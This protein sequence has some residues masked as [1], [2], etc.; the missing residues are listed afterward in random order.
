M[1]GGGP[2]P[3]AGRPKGSRNKATI[4]RELVAAAALER[5]IETQVISPKQ[6][7]ASLEYLLTLALE[8]LD[9]AIADGP[10]AYDRFVA[11]FGRT[12][13][14]AK[15]LAPFQSA[16]YRAIA[17][18]HTDMRPPV[19]DLSRLSNKQIEMMRELVRLAG[20]A[21]TAQG[22]VDQGSDRPLGICDG[23]LMNRRRNGR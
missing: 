20:P 13:D 11:W 2:R 4:K 7:K 6:G 15:A 12:L 5:R 21:N 9:A 1:A 22:P 16:Q 3:G 14:V 18:A 8:R 19:L 23:R 17:V 10:E